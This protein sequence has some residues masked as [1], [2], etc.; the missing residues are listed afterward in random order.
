V[1]KGNYL[2]TFDTAEDAAAVYDN[3]ARKC[4]L[5]TQLNFKKRR[6]TGGEVL[7]LRKQANRKHMPA[8]RGTRKYRGVHWQKNR[9]TWM[10]RYTIFGGGKP[11]HINLGAFAKQEH[12]A[13]AWDHEARK[14]ERVSAALNFPQLDSEGISNNDMEEEAVSLFWPNVKIP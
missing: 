10:A 7:R 12:A 11:K 1:F 14:H 13:L 2:G 5:N 8:I 4:G 6:M 9:K 3:A